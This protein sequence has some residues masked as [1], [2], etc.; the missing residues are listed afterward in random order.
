MPGVFPTGRAM[1]QVVICRFFAVESRVR[2]HVSPCEICGGQSHTGTGFLPVLR[3]SP[4]S[5]ISPMFMV[6]QCI[7]DIKYLTV[8][9]KDTNYAC[10]MIIKKKT[11]WP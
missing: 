7:T 4:V 6:A 5:N 8:Q 9:L 10:Y 11:P 3:F 2:S 1:V